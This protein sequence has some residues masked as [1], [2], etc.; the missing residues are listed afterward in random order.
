MDLPARLQKCTIFSSLGLRSDYYHISLTP[1]AKPKTAYAKTYCK[2][3]WNMDPFGICSLP[4]VSCYLM[5]QVLS[6]L[7][8]CFAYLDDS[9][10]QC[11]MERTSAAS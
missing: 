6:G 10:L 8:F 1:E 2:W 7:D 9:S 5:S 3:Y 11:S 4:G